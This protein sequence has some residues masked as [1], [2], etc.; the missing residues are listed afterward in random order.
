ML[1]L[2]MAGWVIQNLIF[3]MTLNFEK[4]V[5]QILWSSLMKA[6]SNAAPE[7]QF[8][9]HKSERRRLRKMGVAS[10]SQIW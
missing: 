9:L 2:D 3:T 6:T 5:D 4:P 1:Q 7:H 8:T 10:R